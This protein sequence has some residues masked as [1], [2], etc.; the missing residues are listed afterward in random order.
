MNLTITDYTGTLSADPQTWP[1]ELKRAIEQCCCSQSSSSSSTQSSLELIQSGCCTTLLPSLLKGNIRNTTSHDTGLQ[2]RFTPPNTR[3]AWIPAEAWPTIEPANVAGAWASDLFL[4]FE[5]FVDI[6][7]PF[8]G[9]GFP[10]PPP[11][12][13]VH[14]RYKLQAYYYATMG[15]VPLFENPATC[16]LHIFQVVYPNGEMNYTR[17]AGNGYPAVDIT[18]PI[19]W[20]NNLQG[21]GLGSG[22]TSGGIG[23]VQ[24]SV[25]VPGEI[26]GGCGPDASSAIEQ[27]T[28]TGCPTRT[29]PCYQC[30]PFLNSGNL[31]CDNG[32]LPGGNKLIVS[33]DFVQANQTGGQF[34]CAIVLPTNPVY[35]KCRW[36]GAYD[37]SGPLIEVFQ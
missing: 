1:A 6:Q 36:P 23:G 18:Y 14:F 8:Q 20:K 13:Q 27:F 35:E 31:L 2:L 11:M 9:A 19:T 21:G 16:P 25:I 3:P 24:V 10:L 37:S 17:P 30:S 28:S 29:L 32:T 5:K 15:L 4:D 12:G 22:G 26:S 34:S 33:N 7:G